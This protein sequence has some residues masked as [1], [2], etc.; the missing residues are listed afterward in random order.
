MHE[1]QGRMKTAIISWLKSDGNRAF[2]VVKVKGKQV[3]TVFQPDALVVFRA[4][5][6]LGHFRAQSF[7]WHF[8]PEDN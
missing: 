1:V 7:S 5:V 4:K 6:T 3:S 8:S 2:F